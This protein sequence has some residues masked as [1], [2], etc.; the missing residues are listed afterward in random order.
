MSVGLKS[1]GAT[2]QRAMVTLFHGMI[3]RRIECY[4]EDMIA[5]SQTKEGRLA[6]LAKLFDRLRQFRLRLN[7]TKC[8]GGVRSGKLLRLIVNERGIEADPA[9]KKK[10]KKKEIQEMPEPRTEKEA[11]RRLRQYMLVHTTLWISKMDP[12]KYIFEKPA[13]TGRVARGQMI[14]IEY[15][16]QYTSQ[17]AIKGSVLSDYLAQQPIEDYQPMMF[18]LP[19]ED[20]EVLK[21]KDCEEPIPEEGPN[22]EFE[23]ILMSDGAVDVKGNGVGTVLVTPKGSH[24]PFVARITF[25]CTNNGG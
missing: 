12:I 17:K 25:E 14:L 24:I 1:A 18:E 4:V 11:A 10:K 16:V 20:I 22:P 7:P 23:R 15:N 6:D 3:H 2:H 5:K 19:D 21:S 9:K 8:T 13:L